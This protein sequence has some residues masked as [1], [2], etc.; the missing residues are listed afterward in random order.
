MTKQS[1]TLGDVLIQ[2]EKRAPRLFI[3]CMTASNVFWMLTRNIWHELIHLVVAWVLWM[4][5]V[6]M[7]TAQV[8][9]FTLRKKRP[10]ARLIIAALA[11]LIVG[12]VVFPVMLYIVVGMFERTRV[13]LYLAVWILAA[14]F[15]WV[16]GCKNDIQGAAW[17]LNRWARDR[18]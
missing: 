8:D 14:F 1:A 12:L 9:I 5:A 2:I 4:P 15:L 17:L 6:M 13:S 16:D 10:Y 7:S 11:P 3:A 18:K